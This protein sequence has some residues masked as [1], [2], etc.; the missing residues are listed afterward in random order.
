VKFSP[1]FIGRANGSFTILSNDPLAPV[2]T[3]TLTGI[4][5]S[6]PVANLEITPPAV[7]FG[8]GTTPVMVDL[9]NTGEADLL[10]S[11]ILPPT[12]PFGISGGGTGTV[13]SGQKLTLTIT[14]SPSSIGVFQSGLTVVS[15]DPDSLLTFV[16]IRGVSTSQVLV[17]RVVGLEFRKR[18]LRFQA[19]GSNVVTG[20]TL[21]VDGRETFTLELAGDFWVVGKA[22]RSTPGN[23]RVRDIFLSPSTHTV[24]VK[25]PNGG[26]SAP[27][28]LIVYDQHRR[29]LVCS[30]GLPENRAAGT[31]GRPSGQVSG[32]N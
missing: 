28:T 13:K 30:G 26:Q 5:A 17:P 27:V 20:A 23:Q 16:S 14:F 18:G 12:A 7:D 29:F 19:A 9:K 32:I 10:I 15:N 21:I 22:A 6:A 31:D 4:G 24:V 11:S 8:T 1:A 25:N 3:V 2:V